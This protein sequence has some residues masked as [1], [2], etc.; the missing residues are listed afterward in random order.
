MITKAAYIA[1]LDKHFELFFINKAHQNDN[2][3][4]NDTQFYKDIYIR[5][6]MT[7]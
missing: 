5:P 1:S 6:D 2:P 3:I 4:G 7:K